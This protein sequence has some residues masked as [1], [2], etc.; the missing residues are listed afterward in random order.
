[1]RFDGGA[2]LFVG[3]DVLGEGGAGDGVGHHGVRGRRGCHGLS[4]QGVL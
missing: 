1:M 2:D 3:G 4:L